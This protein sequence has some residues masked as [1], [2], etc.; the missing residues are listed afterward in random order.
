MTAENNENK[1]HWKSILN[2]DYIGSHTLIPGKDMILTIK[3][4]KREM[5][6]GQ[7]GKS[8]ECTV[9][10]F[11]ENVKPMILNRLNQKMI[12]K[13][14]KTPYIEDWKGKKI[15]LF[16][17]QV[18]AFGE[19]VDALRIRPFEPKVG[20]PE[21]LE[22]TPKFLEACKFV[23]EGG[24]LKAILTKYDMKKEVK[25]LLE[26]AKPNDNGATK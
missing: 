21:L 17:E 19:M 12:T 25:E 20:K 4:I 13:V 26:N 6:K 16:S 5:V 7:K 11:V 24:D 15:Q 22:G 18:E 14:Y 10:H 3:E 2:M 1:T 9:A 8:E 23:S